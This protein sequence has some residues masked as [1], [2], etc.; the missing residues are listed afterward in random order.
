MIADRAHAS[1]AEELRAELRRLQRSGVAGSSLSKYDATWRQWS[2]WCKRSGLNEWL[3]ADPA[4]HSEQLAF[5]AI[6]C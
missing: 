6:H 2:S 4:K 3:P 5:F 1:D